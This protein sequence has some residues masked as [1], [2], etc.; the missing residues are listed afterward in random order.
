M[1][2]ILKLI[3]INIE[4]QT[5]IKDKVKKKR[6]KPQIKLRHYANQK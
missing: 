1:C 2:L 5:V 4:K 3:K 6:R